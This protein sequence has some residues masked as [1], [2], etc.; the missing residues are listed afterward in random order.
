MIP[1]RIES[2]VQTF[3]HEGKGLRIFL[4]GDEPWFVATDVCAVLE[5]S[6]AREA[7][8]NL[9]ED[10]KSAV[11]IPDAIGREQETNL[12]SESGLYTLILR[13]R[14]P[15]AQPFRRWVT[16]EVLPALRKAG[17]YT[18]QPSLSD[19]QT[20][21]L[22]LRTVIESKATRVAAPPALADKIR[23]AELSLA[24]AHSTLGEALKALSAGMNRLGIS[25]VG[26]SQP[27]SLQ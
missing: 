26:E 1:A 19:L 18:A 11:S 4:Q 13:S 17:T 14:K 16:H 3:T 5:H 22:E 12:I 25:K 27:P 10:E 7:I 2:A 6:N 23:M 20:Q 24:M 21:I 8:R 9:D 15:Q